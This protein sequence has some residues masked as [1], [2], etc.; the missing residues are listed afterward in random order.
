MKKAMC[1]FLA[2]L[3]ILGLAGCGQEKQDTETEGAAEGFRPA[4][5]P[6]VSCHI[7]V[8]GS[9]TTLRPW[10]LNLTDSTSIIPMWSWYLRR[11]TT[12]TTWSEWS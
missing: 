2:V 6:S 11:L 7:S 4:L 3:M 1:M 10:K 5:D 8:A 12:I 9:Y